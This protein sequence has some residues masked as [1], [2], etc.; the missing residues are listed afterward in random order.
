MAP[1][2]PDAMEPTFRQEGARLVL[3]VPAAGIGADWLARPSAELGLPSGTLPRVL[4][5][6]APAA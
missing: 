1:E 3:S 4:Q 5:V 2:A 6:E